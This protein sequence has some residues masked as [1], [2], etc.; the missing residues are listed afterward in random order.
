MSE[1][2]RLWPSWLRRQTQV[3]ILYEGVG[4]NPTGRSFL[5]VRRVI[6]LVV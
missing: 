6:G 1:D 4:S 2:M 3:L 5:S